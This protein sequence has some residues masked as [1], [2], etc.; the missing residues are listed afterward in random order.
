M[1]SA[2][3]TSPEAPVIATTSDPP[4]LRG[5]SGARRGPRRP[6][7]AGR[8][9][10][11]ATPH[12]APSCRPRRAS[13]AA[14]P[15]RPNAEPVGVPPPADHPGRRSSARRGEHV[16]ELVRRVVARRVVRW[17]PSADRR[18]EPRIRLPVA[19]D[20]GLGRS[21]WVAGRRHQPPLSLPGRVCQA[22]TSSSGWSTTLAYWIPFG[23]PRT[24][25]SAV[26][27]P[28]PVHRP[29]LGRPRW[30]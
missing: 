24:A 25:G 23:H 16:D 19:S 14:R 12:R 11:T 30:S 4:R 27:A 15:R 21:A 1:P 13:G 26:F 10:W 9:R 5:V 2:A 7:G 28:V 3:P 22:H 20:S 17:R 8:R 29:R 6:A 18:T